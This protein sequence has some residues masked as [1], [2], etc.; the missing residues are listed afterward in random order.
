MFA[1]YVFARLLISLQS[2]L[3]L[4]ARDQASRN[5]DISTSELG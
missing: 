5:E 1:V 3:L 4:I 2:V